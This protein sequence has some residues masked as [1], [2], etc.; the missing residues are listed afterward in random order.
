MILLLFFHS[1]DEEADDA[2][3]HQGHEDP[4]QEH[5]ADVLGDQVVALLVDD[6]LEA[7]DDHADR[8]EVREGREEDGEDGLIVAGVALAYRFF[9]E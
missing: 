8:A 4:G 1:P 6:A 7:A 9:L 3:G 2:G 5:A